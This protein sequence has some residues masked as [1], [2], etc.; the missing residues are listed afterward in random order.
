MEDF[1][2]DRKNGVVRPAPVH[3]LLNLLRDEIKALVLLYRS[4]TE[5][6]AGNVKAHKGTNNMPY[7][8]ARACEWDARS[9][10][11][12]TETIVALDSRTI[13]DNH[14]LTTD[15]NK[16]MARDVLVSIKYELDTLKKL[17][18]MEHQDK[19]TEDMKCIKSLD[20]V[21]NSCQ[22][23]Y[24][25]FA[26]YDSGMFSDLEALVPTE[27]WKENHYPRKDTSLTDS[28]DSS[29]ATLTKGGSKPPVENNNA[30]SRIARISYG[31]Q[32]LIP[33]LIRINIGEKIE[34]FSFKKNYRNRMYPNP[35]YMLEDCLGESRCNKFIRYKVLFDTVHRFAPGYFMTKQQRVDLYVKTWL[36]EFEA[37]N[38]GA[39]PKM[40][41]PQYKFNMETV[42]KE[43][44]PNATYMLMYCIDDDSMKG[45]FM[46]C[47]ILIFQ[48]HLLFSCIVPMDKT[49]PTDR[50]VY[51]QCA[52]CDKMI[53]Q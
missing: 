11:Q 30:E 5:S 28:R 43:A 44:D 29:A 8:Q 3:A 18:H 31:N 9:I 15:K 35:H 6:N 13:F 19:G 53:M 17:V 36:A 40:Y 42:T 50:R 48:D 4:Y 46:L 41:A 10:E 26:T 14:P 21:L 38:Y 16:Q 49:R 45:Y 52:I 24:K 7:N 20:T 2:R 22:K 51:Q 23:M 33:K 37:V 32:D 12:L 1:L 47:N 34:P 27:H 39:K 25:I